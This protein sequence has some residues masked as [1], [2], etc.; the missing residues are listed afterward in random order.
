M[1]KFVVSMAVVIVACAGAQ[2]G[3][4]EHLTFDID[5]TAAT[6][7]DAVL[8]GDA[9]VTTGGMG[10]SGEALQLDGDGDFATTPG[11]KGIAGADARTVSL[12]VKTAVNQ[13]DGTFF[14]GWGDTGFGSRVRY[15]LGLQ[16]GTSDQLRNEL[17]AGAIT[18]NTGTT[19]T[20][21][22]WHHISLTFDGTTTTFYVDGQTY[23]TSTTSVNTTT[24]EDLVIGTGIRPATEFNE[25]ARWTN[26]LI[27]DVQIYD[28][29]LTGD[30]VATLYA[31]PGTVV[32]E[33]ATLAIL[34]IG[35]L[36]LGRRRK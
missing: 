33:P 21:D 23:G 7:T 4:V 14:L 35:A 11:F 13:A 10:I 32:P 22:A 27:D 26:G 15:D 16:K 6:G 30:Q 20:D 25:N 12:W 24:T 31:N 36:A 18:S 2:A 5:G 19:I 8:V 1:K 3:I 34:G 28:E 17:N 9:A 29:A